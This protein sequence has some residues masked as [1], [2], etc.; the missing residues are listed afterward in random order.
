MAVV[1]ENFIE[2]IKDLNFD[3]VACGPGLGKITPKTLKNLLELK[4]FSQISHKIFLT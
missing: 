4:F 2:Q 1:A 3:A